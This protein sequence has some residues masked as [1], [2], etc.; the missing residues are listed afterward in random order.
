MHE[1]TQCPLLAKQPRSERVTEDEPK[2]AKIARRT[3]SNS[4]SGAALRDPCAPSLSSSS[5]LSREDLPVWGPRAAM[6]SLRERMSTG[7]STMWTRAA[8]W[9]AVRG[10]SPVIM[11][12]RWLECCFGGAETQGQGRVSRRRRRVEEQ[13][14][15][16]PPSDATGIRAV[17]AGYTLSMARA[18]SLSGFTGHMKTAKP[19]NWSCDSAFSLKRKGRTWVTDTGNSNIWCHEYSKTPRK[20]H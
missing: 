8:T 15:L 19:T 7:R 14:Q 18:G 10:A 12:R 5:C 4:E 1:R 2:W 20:R 17:G 6:L 16:E 13:L 9:Q 3:H 11:T